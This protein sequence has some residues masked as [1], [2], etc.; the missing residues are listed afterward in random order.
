MGSELLFGLPTV[1]IDSSSEQRS[2]SS[3]LAGVED[4]ADDC[5]TMTVTQWTKDYIKILLTTSSKVLMLL[6]LMLSISS[7]GKRSG[8]KESSEILFPEAYNS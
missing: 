8:T 2:G 3:L 5:K 7:R 1:M 6:Q 4:L